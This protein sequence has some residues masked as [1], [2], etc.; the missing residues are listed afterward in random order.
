ML[1][2]KKFFKCASEKE[3][4]T[5]LV[6]DILSYPTLQFP[7]FSYPTIFSLA[8]TPVINNDRFPYHLHAFHPL[9]FCSFFVS[10]S[11]TAS[12]L[13]LKMKPDTGRTNFK[14]NI[15]PNNGKNDQAD[16]KILMLLI[17]ITRIVITQRALKISQKNCKNI[18]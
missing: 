13:P 7:I 5:F 6:F 10:A 4:P 8:P 16:I 2:A 14:F 9:C 3:Y 1:G 11:F 18:I 12:E 15:K 17:G